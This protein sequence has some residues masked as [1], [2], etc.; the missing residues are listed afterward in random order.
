MSVLWGS[1]WPFVKIALGEIPPWTF[2][3]LCVVLSACCLL[4]LAKARGLKLSFPTKQLKPLILVSLLN[5]TGWNL[6]SAYGISY[7]N[8][9]RAVIIGF[10][11][12]V[13][14]SILGIFILKER[15]SLRRVLGLALG[16]LGLAILL[17]PDVKAMGS[18]PLGPAFML[19]SAVSWAAGTV[20]VKYFRWTTQPALLTAWLFV[21]GGIPVVLGA[22]VLEPSTAI[23]RLS[24]KG[25]LAAAY[26]SM[27]CMPI[28]WW[29]WFKVVALLPSGTA[30]LGTIAAP[31]VGVFSSA[32]VLR[33]PIGFQEI[34]A[35]FCVVLALAIV[36]IGLGGF[37]RRNGPR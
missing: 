9:G 16:M 22:W 6:L 11:M 19:G 15:L 29:A 24:L 13:W 23:F 25:A 2:R 26:V 10:T 12:P 14:A 30:A 3:T 20:L 1:A 18:G 4:A 35:L 7:M 5:V 36:L 27:F 33:E 32:L 37:K 28:G 34:A 17:G 31:V 21:L 8:A